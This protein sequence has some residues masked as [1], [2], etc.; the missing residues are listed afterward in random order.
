MVMMALKQA[1]ETRQHGGRSS[2]LQHTSTLRRASSGESVGRPSKHSFH[3]QMSNRNMTSP[4]QRTSS[5]GLGSAKSGKSVRSF[6]SRH[7]SKEDDSS[8]FVC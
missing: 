3:N 2:D 5:S 6:Y 8:A 4:S 7:D 1:Y